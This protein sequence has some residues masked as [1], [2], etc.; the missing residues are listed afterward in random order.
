MSADD[1]TTA[2]LLRLNLGD[3][4]E[5]RI[6]YCAHFVA[7]ALGLFSRHGVEVRFQQAQDG[8]RTT[9]GGQIPA[10]LSDEAD[11]AVGGPMV[12]MKMAEDNEAHLAVFCAVANSNPWVLARPEPGRFS[13]LT[14]LA[15]LRVRDVAN[16]GTATMAFR[17]AL[18][19]A[20]LSPEDVEILPAEARSTAPAGEEVVL[21]SRHALAERLANGELHVWR[22]LS[23]DTGSVP[24]SAYIAAPA[25]LS[26]QPQAFA[27]FVAAIGAAQRFIATRSPAEIAALIAQ[28]YPEHSP[29]ALAAGIEGYLA[30]GVIAQTPVIAQQDFS[31]FSQLLEAIGWL[32]RPADYHHLV[33]T[34]LWSADSSLVATQEIS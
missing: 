12:I 6:Y 19:K 5:S 22:D 27:A 9:R 2:P 28:D 29:A 17:D 33:D 26:R 20:G 3:A 21:Q 18:A 32:E 31:R 34:R 4:S 10:L 14:E 15:G 23:E 1:G 16:V 24:W 11:L 8:G 7:R 13:S 25:T 30:S